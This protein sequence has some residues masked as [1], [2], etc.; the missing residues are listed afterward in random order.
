MRTVMLMALTRSRRG[1]AGVRGA[2]YDIAVHLMSIPNPDLDISRSEFLDR[3]GNLLCHIRIEL[4]E[5]DA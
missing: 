4:T 1:N 2:T 5:L 3:R